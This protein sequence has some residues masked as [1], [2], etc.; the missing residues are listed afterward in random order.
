MSPAFTVI[1][2]TLPPR[3]A[4]FWAVLRAST[5]GAKN[6]PPSWVVAIVIVGVPVSPEASP[7]ICG[8]PC[9]DLSPRKL[10]VRAAVP[11]TATSSRLES[12]SSA[13]SMS[14]LTSGNGIGAVVWPSKVSVNVPPVAPATVIV[15][16]SFVS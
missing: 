15:W 13:A 8:T 1:R 2:S 16:F 10:T 7:V 3:C 14:A 5:C 9:S 12:A 6:Q 4:V 11:V